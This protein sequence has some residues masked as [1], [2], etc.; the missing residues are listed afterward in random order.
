MCGFEVA[1]EET[2]LAVLGI[3]DAAEVLRVDLLS[4]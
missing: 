4:G 3:K 2:S 1:D